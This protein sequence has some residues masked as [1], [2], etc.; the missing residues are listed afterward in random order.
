[1][2]QDE[3]QNPKSLVC[4][5]GKK[6]GDAVTGALTIHGIDVAVP[7][8]ILE[9]ASREDFET[10]IRYNY[11]LREPHIIAVKAYH[12]KYLT[13]SIPIMIDDEL[14]RKSREMVTFNHI[15]TYEPPE[16]YRY[17]MPQVLLKHALRGDGNRVKK[18]WKMALVDSDMDGAL[19]LI[20]SFE[21]AFIKNQ[22]NSL[23]W[24]HY[25]DL[26]REESKM[27]EQIKNKPKKPEERVDSELPWNDV[28]KSYVEHV[29]EGLLECQGMNISSSFVPSVRT[30][31]SSSEKYVRDQ[32]K[33]LNRASAFLWKEVLNG[34]SFPNGRPW[35][36]ICM[37]KSIFMKKGDKETSMEDIIDVIETSLDTKAHCGICITMTGWEDVWADQ[38]S[39]SRL[40][41]FIKQVSEIAFMNKMPIYAARSK[42]IGIDLLDSGLT[43]AGSIMS[44]KETIRKTLGG[45]VNGPEI[46]G[47]TPIYGECEE[48]KVYELFE[49]VSNTGE[50]GNPLE[51]H[52]FEGIENKC[53]PALL[54]NPERFRKEFSKPRRIATHTQEVREVRN[55]LNRGVFKPGREYVRRSQFNQYLK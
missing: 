29:L 18:F 50:L 19:S 35:Y 14:N 4:L 15:M 27:I 36:H 54:S 2:P 8:F 37:D 38:K 11:L 45:S 28:N 23:I 44:G 30:L 46:F 40:H 52:K 1:M 9:T 33:K 13:E 16:Y 20:P 26:K 41:D 47:S 5:E 48:Y 22:W 25:N 21:R 31:K 43:F 32:V 55:D 53:D 34:G 10:M 51:L 3:E 39:R 17:S 49:E 6:V 24:Q 12:W 42:W 7:S